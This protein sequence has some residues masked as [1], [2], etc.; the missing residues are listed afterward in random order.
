MQYISILSQQHRAHNAVRGGPGVETQVLQSNLILESFGNTRTSRNDTS[1]KFIEMSF[2]AW[3]KNQS[4]GER[5]L[6][7][8]ATIDFYLLEKV[9]LVSINPGE[10]NCHIFHKILSPHEMSI[11]DKRCYMLTPDFGKGR[12]P[13]T[14]KDFSMIS[15]SGTFDK[16]NGVDDS[17][18]Y[19][20]LW[21]A[22][23]TV[24]FLK[25]DQDGMFSL[26]AALLH[27]SNFQFVN[28]GNRDCLVC[29]N[30]ATP[31]AV[32]IL[33]AVSEDSLKM[34]LTSSV[35]K[36]GGE[37]LT[38]R[39]SSLQAQKALEA[40]VKAT[41]GALFTYI[42]TR[43]N[44]SIEVQGVHGA[45]DLV[46]D[47][48]CS[49]AWPLAFPTMIYSCR[50]ACMYAPYPKMRTTW[51]RKSAFFLTLPFPWVIVPLV[52]SVNTHSWADKLSATLRIDC[53]VGLLW[54]C[55]K[56]EWKRKSKAMTSQ[57]AYIVQKNRVD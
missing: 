3:K 12:L 32:S 19:R 48:W 24:G 18:T 45:D 50:D 6:L 26:M 21:T 49:N 5:G 38:K 35:I 53:S 4:S 41:Y 25:E 36:L 17:D 9:Q 34:S 46:N 43:I 52:G 23:D 54:S 42:A 51:V 30:N 29:D 57:T 47:Q 2:Q 33:L 39:L 13:L 37:L 22:L 31:E 56:Q 55:I 28:D 15:I 10:R 20:E 1:R 44:E 14:V 16:R 8:G 11:K 27:T 7:L 40:T